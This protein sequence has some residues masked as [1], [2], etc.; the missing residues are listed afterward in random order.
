MLNKCYFNQTKHQFFA[1]VRQIGVKIAG[2]G[3][4]APKLVQW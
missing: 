2:L 1:I 4:K 3:L